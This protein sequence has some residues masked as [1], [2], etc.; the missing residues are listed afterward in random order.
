MVP[1]KITH[2]IALGGRPIGG[3]R[4]RASAFAA[5]GSLGLA[6][7][8]SEVIDRDEC[9]NED[10]CYHLTAANL[11]SGEPKIVKRHIADGNRDVS[12]DAHCA[13]YNRYV[14]PTVH[15]AH[16]RRADMT[17]ARRYVRV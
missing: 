10:C 3:Q 11:F 12:C 13:S 6:Q 16:P 14:E 1:L 8:L 4:L 7:L 2:P 5:G 17:F 9:S 15:R